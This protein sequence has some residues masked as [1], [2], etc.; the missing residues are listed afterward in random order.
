MALDWWIGGLVDCWIAGGMSTLKRVT[1]GVI[2]C[3]HKT[4]PPTDSRLNMTGRWDVGQTSGLPVQ[5]D[6]VSL[7][8]STGLQSKPEPA[9][10]RSAPHFFLIS[11]FGVRVYGLF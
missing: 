3:C 10:R 4:C 8:S 7:N 11:N 1:K 9:D 2:I 5:G 6:S